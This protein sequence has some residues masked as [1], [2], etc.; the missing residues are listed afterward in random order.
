M[1]FTTCRLMV[2]VAP[3]RDGN[4]VIVSGNHSVD[5]FHGIRA[6]GAGGGD[7]NAGKG[8]SRVT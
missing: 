4:D 5:K 1:E 7:V 2:L 3:E 6:N 8:N